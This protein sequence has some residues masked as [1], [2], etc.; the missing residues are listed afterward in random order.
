MLT[1]KD[2]RKVLDELWLARARWYIIGLVLN[3]DVN[4]LEAIRME[5]RDNPDKCLT[6]VIRSYLINPSRTKSWSEIITALKSPTVSY[7]L[8]AEELKFKFLR[9]VTNQKRVSAPGMSTEA[10][11]IRNS[12]SPLS[13]SYS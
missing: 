3:V 4:E 8:L 5:N 12:R 10:T 6:S 2:M 13:Q 11:I 7:G 1:S 9:D